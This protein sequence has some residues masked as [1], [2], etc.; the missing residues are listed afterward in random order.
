MATIDIPGVTKEDLERR[1]RVFANIVAKYYGD[2]DFKAKVD[3][4]PTEALRKEGMDI[5]TGVSVKLLINSDKVMH[6]VLPNK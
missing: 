4:N 1:Q 5:P 6:I 2:P 3:A